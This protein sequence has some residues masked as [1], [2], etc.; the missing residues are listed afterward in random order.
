VLLASTEEPW[1]TERAKVCRFGTAEAPDDAAACT[2][3]AAAVTGEPGVFANAVLGPAPTGSLSSTAS[4]TLKE[5]A[6]AGATT[7]ACRTAAD[8]SDAS[9][10]SVAGDKA[11]GLS[12]SPGLVAGRTLPG[13]VSMATASTGVAAPKT[14]ELAAVTPCKIWLGA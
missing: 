2:E 3:L 6:L 12:E 1:E 9:L 11:A 14:P 8:A 5:V 10:V 7:G 13:T 4:G